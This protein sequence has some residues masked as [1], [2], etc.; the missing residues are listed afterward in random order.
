MYAKKCNK[1]WINIYHGNQTS[2]LKDLAIK[3]MANGHLICP[4]GQFWLQNN[5]RGTN[6]MIRSR[7][8]KKGKIKREEKKKSRK[9]L[10]ML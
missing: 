6:D 3:L 7:K 8:E 9:E 5:G 4:D 2:T 10:C 1:N